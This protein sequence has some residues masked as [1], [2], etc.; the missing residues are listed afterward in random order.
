MAPINRNGMKN[1]GGS[2][3]LMIRCFVGSK[4]VKLF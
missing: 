4:R 1:T 2:E 3:K